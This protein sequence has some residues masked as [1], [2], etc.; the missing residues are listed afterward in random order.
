MISSYKHPESNNNDFRMIY[1]QIANNRADS[2]A[3]VNVRKLDKTEF[4]KLIELL[5][6]EEYNANKELYNEYRNW[7]LRFPI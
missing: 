4:D 6:P 1:H 7:L 2:G 5:Y 3:H